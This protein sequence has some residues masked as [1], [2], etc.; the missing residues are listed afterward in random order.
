MQSEK[1]QDFETSGNL[2]LYSH[3]A[4]QK[5]GKQNKLRMKMSDLKTGYKQL[6]IAFVQRSTVKSQ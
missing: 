2:V 4:M 5:K 3:H 6:T 1:L